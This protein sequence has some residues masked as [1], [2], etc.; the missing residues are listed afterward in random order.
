[1]ATMGGTPMTG[2]GPG[3]QQMSPQEQ[4]QIRMI[5]GAMESC[6]VKTGMA[7]VVG[8]AMGAAFGLFMSSFEFS[9]PSMDPKLLEQSTKVQ[10]KAVFKDMKT[11]SFSMA[12]NFAVVGAIYSG[13]ECCIESYR[14]KNDLGNS[15]AAGCFTGGVLAARAGPQAAALGCAGFAAFSCAI[16]YYMKS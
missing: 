5:Q 14:A 8:G 7:G 9:G 1:M 11:R 2:G 3:Q 13:S 15:M 10:M 12:K 4:A 6:P 16:D